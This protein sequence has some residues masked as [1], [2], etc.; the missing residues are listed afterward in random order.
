MGS[1]SCWRWC[2][3]I[4][5]VIM[6]QSH[7]HTIRVHVGICRGALSTPRSHT[8]VMRL[9]CIFYIPHTWDSSS[10]NNWCH[11]ALSPLLSPPLPPLLP[12]PP[13][14]PLFHVAGILWYWH[15]SRAR[16]ELLS[17]KK[18]THPTL[19][20]QRPGPPS[21]DGERPETCQFH[22]TQQGNG[23]TQI[24]RWLGWIGQEPFLH[25]DETDILC[26]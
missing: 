14:L 2:N 11:T 19:S 13:S 18:A 5:N 8:W 26:T 24:W 6:W 3:F 21:G 25:S 23:R 15:W 16:L 4:C 7:D 9:R 10:C 22:S 20:L 1:H 12:L 17:D